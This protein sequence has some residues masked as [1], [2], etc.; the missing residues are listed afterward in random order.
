MLEASRKDLPLD[1]AA[2]AAAIDEC[3]DCVQACVSDAEAD[4]AEDH[5]DDLRKCIA[6]C[7]NCADV[8]DATAR[9]LARSGQWDQL[10]VDRLLQACVRI[11]T[12]C[13]E[14]CAKHADHHRHCAVCE[15]SCRA[16]IVACSALLGAEALMEVQ[17]LGGV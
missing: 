11:C 12:T 1:A 7:M 14:E 15:T 9:V 10:V 5:V 6:L 16:C 17:A 4:L 3:L 8:C 13:A 2:V